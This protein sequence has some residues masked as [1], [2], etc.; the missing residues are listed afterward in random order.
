MGGGGSKIWELHWDDG[1]ENG[2]YYLGFRVRGLRF[3]RIG[4]TILGVIILRIRMFWG[5]YRGS[6][7]PGNYRMTPL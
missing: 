3:P 4:G 7:I 2:N 1:E 5:L 6:P